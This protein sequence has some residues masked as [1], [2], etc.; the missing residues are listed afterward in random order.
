ML[1]DRLRTDTRAAHRAAE[2]SPAMQALM[3]PGLTRDAY[4]DHLQ[5]VA[6]GLVPLEAGLV[7]VPGLPARVS[8][9]ADRLHKRDWLAAD[10]ATLGGA[11]PTAG[12]APALSL[13][14][15]L[16][17]LYVLEGATLGGRIIEKHLAR[18]LGL[19]P[20]TGAR[21]YHA[22]GEARG[23]MWVAL[24][25]ALDAFGAEQPHQAD[26]VVQ[27]ADAAFGALA[28]ALAEPAAP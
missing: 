28:A 14:E 6:R 12:P 23:P 21:Y 22:Y 27:A 18:T 25:D 8:A 13:A 16:G 5:G 2:A 15:A 3:A 11:M 19:A 26:A 1:S 7:A 17:T 24:R 9:L 10:L 4:H 20:D